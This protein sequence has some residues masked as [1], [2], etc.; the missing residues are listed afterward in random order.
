MGDDSLDLPVLARAGLA[1]AP[2]DAVDEVRARATAS[3]Q[4]RR[5]GRRPRIVERILRVQGLWQ[6]VVDAYLNE[7]NR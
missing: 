6:N 1:A 4:P 5:R 3:P 2:A 7:P